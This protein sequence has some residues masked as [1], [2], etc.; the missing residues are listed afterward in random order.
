MSLI[1]I[2]MLIIN[3]LSYLSIKNT[4]H[5]LVPSSPMCSSFSLFVLHV[6]DC[7]LA[8]ATHTN[9]SASTLE[10][11]FAP[12]TQVTYSIIKIIIIIISAVQ[13]EADMEEIK[14]KLAWGEYTLS[15]QNRKGLAADFIIRR[16]KIKSTSVFG[17][18]ADCKQVEVL[19]FMWHFRLW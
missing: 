1:A 16:D 17:K 9:T 3:K 19:L 18:C 12:F 11:L 13:F 4:K 6:L 5:S 2:D 14:N 15:T 8:K 7:W 10:H